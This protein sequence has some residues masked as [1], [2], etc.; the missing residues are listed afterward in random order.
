MHLFSPCSQHKPLLFCPPS[1]SSHAFSVDF[2]SA[3][4]RLPQPYQIPPESHQP[5]RP[6]ARSLPWRTAR[7]VWPWRTHPDSTALRLCFFSFTPILSAIPVVTNCSVTWAPEWSHPVGSPIRPLRSVSLCARALWGPSDE[8]W[9]ESAPASLTP[10]T[11]IINHL[12]PP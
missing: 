9:S 3:V 2:S 6:A 10:S 11:S 1:P 12:D 7:S 4:G 5:S 8:R